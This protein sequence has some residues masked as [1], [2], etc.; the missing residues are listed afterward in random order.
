S[1]S[2]GATQLAPSPTTTI[3]APAGPSRSPRYRAATPSAT[4]RLRAIRSARGAISVFAS[5]EGDAEL[6]ERRERRPRRRVARRR[7]VEGERGQQ[8]HLV[9]ASAPQRDHEPGPH[10]LHTSAGAEQVH[11]QRG[12]LRERALERGGIAPAVADEEQPD[13]AGAVVLE[14]PH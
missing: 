6:S 10:H 3:P 14:L 2:Q 13:V 1:R 7:R 8:T 12:R 5:A 4:S 9:P 11:G